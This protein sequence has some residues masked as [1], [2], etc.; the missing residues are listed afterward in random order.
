MLRFLADRGGA[1]CAAFLARAVGWFAT[2][3]TPAVRV[4]SDNGP[5]QS[6]GAFQVARAA[7]GV[8][9][10]R[11]RIYTPR[12]NGKANRVIQTLLRA[13]LCP[14]RTRASA[15]RPGGPRQPSWSTT[16]TVAV[17]RKSQR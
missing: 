9:P 11:R 12:A 17:P 14:R 16:T 5:R 4:L 1:S 15:G 13:D 8:R 10:R 7:L 3:G 6:V 2:Q